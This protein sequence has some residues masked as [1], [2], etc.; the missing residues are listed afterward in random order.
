M[1]MSLEPAAGPVRNGNGKNNH[2]KPGYHEQTA[3]DSH[4]DLVLLWSEQTLRN[5]GV[6]PNSSLKETGFEL[7]KNP[8]QDQSNAGADHAHNMTQKL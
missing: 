6:F 4:V 5:G 3:Q 1:T 8:T 2:Q 7:V